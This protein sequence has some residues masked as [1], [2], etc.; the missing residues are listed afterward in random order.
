MRVGFGSPR[1]FFVKGERTM[2]AV[3]G[4]IP[5]DPGA[6]TFVPVMP[7]VFFGVGLRF[8]IRLGGVVEKT[9]GISLRNMLGTE[10]DGRC[11]EP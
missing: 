6:L 5:G 11:C 3:I 8:T 4:K 10:R 9:P 2:E 7:A 1:R